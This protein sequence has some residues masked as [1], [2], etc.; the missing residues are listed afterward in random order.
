[1]P[2]EFFFLS[3]HE[4]S[5]PFCGIFCYNIKTSECMHLISWRDSFE[6]DLS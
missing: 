5:L 4:L 3:F 1:V 2:T 6:R